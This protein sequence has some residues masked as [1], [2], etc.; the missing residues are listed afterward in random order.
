MQS[1]GCG[2]RIQ[3][4][5]TR[6]C[7]QN[8]LKQNTMLL[9]LTLILAAMAQLAIAQQGDKAGQAQKLLVP[10]EKI[11]PSPPL[12]PDDAL[13]TFKLPD[14]FRMELVAAE[15]M[16]ETP[17]AATFDPDGRLWV[18]EMRGFMPNPEG[19]GE[20]QPVG[21]IS[22]LEDTN[23]DGRMDKSTIYVEGL[24]MPRS[25]LL[26]RQGLLV[27][28]PP[29]L[30]FFR[31][32]NGDGKADEKNLVANDYAT[33]ADPKLGPRANHEHSSNGLMW[34]LDNWI[35]SA[36]H[37]TR[38]RNVTGLWQREPTISRGQWGMTQDDFGRLFFN[39]NSDQ[40]RGDVVPTHYLARNPNYRNAIGGNVQMTRN[41][42]VWPGRVNPGV[43]RGY[44]QGQLRADGTLATFTAA[45]GPVI[46]RG[47]QFPPEFRGNAFVCE[48]T[49][50]LIKRNLLIETNAAVTASNAYT[51][52]EFLT[53]TDERFRPVNLYN[54]PDGA[55]YVIDM[56]H[57][58]LQH[59]IYLTSYLRQQALD[60][61]LEK[62]TN[63]G[64]IYRVVNTAAKPGT[65]PRL[66]QASSADLV[67]TLTH[68]NGWWRDTAQ[69]LLVERGDLSV[70]PELRKVAADN[71]NPLAQ[72]HALWTLD[73]LS[74][75]DRAT[76]L[77]ALG[78]A[79]PK[80]RAAA[81]RVSEPL[82]KSSARAEL[83]P[84][85][86]R[87]ADDPNPD[88][89][90]QLAFTLGETSGAQA[91][92]AMASVFQKN[93]ANVYVRDAVLTG[94][95]GRELEF[96]ERLLNHSA[97]SAKSPTLDQTLRLL[98]QCVFAEANFDRVSRLLELAAQQTA[99]NGWRQLALLDGILGTTQPTTRGRP[100]PRARPLQ[101]KA[102][103]AA[104][105]ALNKIENPEVRTRMEK[106]GPMMVWPGKSGVDPQNAVKP[107]TP[108]QQA[109][110]N[111]G[112]ELYVATCGACHQPHGNGQEGLAPPLL[113][114]EWSTGPEQRLVRIALHGV[115]GSI[116][117]KGKKYDMDMPPLSVLDDEQIA[118]ILT[119]VR[120][121]WGH[122]ASPIEPAAVAKIRA[123]NAKR[124]DAWSEAELL[125]IP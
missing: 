112:K 38:F 96:L 98:A 34:A 11:P 46:Y 74:Q 79:H 63:W 102:E 47:E 116:T 19:V 9:R 5:V 90:L 2:P 18:L 68:P 37:T 84:Q 93:A 108:E 122:T 87:L 45:C 89:Q 66:S 71:S 117:V 20:D 16:I 41:Q 103:P 6:C 22:V 64:R 59:R 44:Q 88:V 55:L 121:E 81:I 70:V 50:N 77:G 110:F 75:T 52:T 97:W 12:S 114:S 99:T 60:R 105:A 57:G 21:R 39:S 119:Y 23:G 113:D 36:N 27:A 73:G 111:A 72:L 25:L 92:E 40:L 82:P 13:K 76:L 7:L 61:G 106:I 17:T 4:A 120:R 125:K 115:R 124:E 24:V 54:A 48:P 94:L 95:G 3:R 65:K 86:L 101:L 85:L 43:N 30:W 1:I 51:N 69:R 104:L 10:R 62:P 33:G 118:N 91:E 107:L 29:N 53:S 26:F 80:I 58:I 42:T 28:E 109:R 83:L 67:K 15:P 8:I 78:S 35:Y 123:D 31:D 14:G 56:Y 32:T 49:G 100:A